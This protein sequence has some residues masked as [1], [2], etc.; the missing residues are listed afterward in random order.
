[1][2]RQTDFSGGELD[3]Q[4]HGRTDL[5][6]FGKGL[7][8]ALNFFISRQGA[9]VSRGGTFYLGGAK[10]V[11]GPTLGIRDIGQVWLVPFDAGASTAEVRYD[12]EVLV[13]DTYTQSYVL[14]FG[15]GYIRFWSDDAQVLDAG[16]NIYEVTEYTLA[17]GVTTAPLPYSSAS[18]KRLSWAQLGDVLILTHPWYPA[19]ELRRHGHATWVAREVT[20]ARSEL[21]DNGYTDT[22]NP[23]NATTGFLFVSS[24]AGEQSDFAADADHPAREWQWKVTAIVQDPDTGEKFETLPDDILERCDGADFDTVQNISDDKCQLYPDQPVVLRRGESASLLSGEYTL[25]IIAY[26]FYRGRGKLF[27]FVGTTTS[28]EFVDVGDTPNYARQPPLGTNPFEVRDAAT[29]ALVRTERPVAVTHFQSKRWFG[30][31]VG[32]D[33]TPQR[34][35]TILGSATEDFYD[36]DQKLIFDVAGEA[37]DFTLAS[38]RREEIRHLLSRNKLLVGTASSWW[39]VNG[40]QG[41]PVDYDHVEAEMIDEV[42]T[43]F[44]RPALVDGTLVFARARG[45]GVRALVAQGAEGYQGFDVS[46]LAQHLFVGPDKHIIQFAYTRDP[47]G[48]L[49]A[50]TADGTLYSL[51]YV[52]EGMMAWTHH[53][54]DGVVESICSVPQGDED[55]LYLSIVRTIGTG[56]MEDGSPDKHRYIERMT[57]RHARGGAVVQAPNVV[58]TDSDYICIDSALEYCGAAITSVITGLDHLE[59]KEVYVVAEGNPVLGPYTVVDG[60]IETG[61]IATNVT[62]D[63]GTPRLLAYVGMAFTCDLELLDVAGGEARMRQKQVTHVCFEVSSS[64]NVQVGQDFD[65]LILVPEREIT[66]G[67]G[68]PPL[69]T[70][71]VKCAVKGKSDLSARACLRQDKPI[72]MTV[73]G[74]SRRLAGG[75]S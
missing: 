56:T 25:H 7:R 62:D 33:K 75:D 31:T 18:L 1:M 34:I 53:E 64:K 44:A 47:W 14:E 32:E 27:G 42:G 65:H 46:Q 55:A 73:V 50:I 54:L 19:I 71:V 51:T 57:S 68:A 52:K 66:D 21:A 38:E 3:P 48:V 70:K 16:L 29:G 72:P 60:Q 43:G 5:P 4:L 61:P 35:E 10:Y 6:V 26:N 15:N 17:D 24:T 8:T 49:W 69:Q 2:T 20:F 9:A 67:F 39:S 40:G 37:L 36:F 41:Q 58:L 13:N 59:G 30:G 12:G 63:T 22:D 11:D 23:A 45:A 28:R 74:V